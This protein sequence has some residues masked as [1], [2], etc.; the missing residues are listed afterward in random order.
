[1]RAAL[2]I[3]NNL[4][5]PGAAVIHKARPVRLRDLINSKTLTVIQHRHIV[6][7]LLAWPNRD[8]YRIRYA[9]LQNL[10]AQIPVDAIAV[11]G[12]RWCIVPFHG[13]R[14]ILPART[15][16]H[17]SLYFG[18]TANQGRANAGQRRDAVVHFHV[19]DAQHTVDTVQ[20]GLKRFIHIGCVFRTVG[21]L[22]ACPITIIRIIHEIIKQAVDAFTIECIRIRSS[23]GKHR[24][25]PEP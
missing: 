15:S 7:R 20:D 12:H 13:C 24:I 9:V 10:I 3:G 14:S 17:E 22:T 11:V 6:V 23:I 1:M 25:K 19:T 21:I 4:I 5:F 8:V 2:R 18:G 16:V